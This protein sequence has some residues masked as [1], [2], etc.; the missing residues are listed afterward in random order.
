MF[1]ILTTCYNCEAFIKECIESAL[2]QNE[3]E[4]EMYII[5]D[6]ST[7]NTL[8]VAKKASNGDSRI[9]ILS[10]KKN[11]GLTFNQTL[12]FVHHAK[13]ND[14]D[15]IIILDGDDYFLHPKVLSYIKE[16]YSKGYWF[17]YGG[18]RHSPN[19]RMPEDFYTEINWSVSLRNQTFCLS[20]LRSYK[21]FLLKNIKN[22][23]LKDKKNNFFEFGVDVALGIPMVEMAGENRCFH[24]KDGLYYYRYHKDNVHRSV[25]KDAQRSEYI[26]GDL[27][28]RTPYAKKNKRAIA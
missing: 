4:W 3:N 18:I 13:P 8:K 2:A 24:V 11:N 7:D 10:N 16:I 20:H 27:S 22:I 6:A 1:K 19:F 5:D 15:V 26:Q 14:E 12:N 25:I 9:K 23:D 21:F 17:T 28:F